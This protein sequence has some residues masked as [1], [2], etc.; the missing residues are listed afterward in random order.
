MVAIEA[1]FIEVAETLSLLIQ[2][3]L[4]YSCKQQKPQ[5]KH[6]SLPDY[7]AKGMPSLTSRSA[8]LGQVVC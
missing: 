2:P 5:A 6:H 3:V 7:L 1:F 4:M 8:G